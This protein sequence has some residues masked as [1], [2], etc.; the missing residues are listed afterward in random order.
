MNLKAQ[1]AALIKAAQETISAAKAED[2]DLTDA[3]IAD[4]ETKNA[5]IED[6]TAKLEK[7]E[8]S[9]ALVQSLTGAGAAYAEGQDGVTAGA[10]ADLSS[11]GSR[12]TGSKAYTG[13][14]AA[15]P[16]GVGQG[17][18]VDIGKVS[19]GSGDEWFKSR[20]L[21]K[22]GVIGSPAA[23]VEAARY[24]TVVLAERTE[25]TLLDLI[26]RGTANG[27][28]EYLQ[29][30]SVTR[31]GAVVP[32]ATNDT[33]TASLKPQSDFGTNLADAKP[34]TYAD[35]Y[36][37]TNQLLADAPALASYLNSEVSYT[38]DGVI[39]DKWLNGTGLNGEPRGLLNTTGV[40]SLE[41]TEAVGD[42][43]PLVKA[44]RRGITGI[45]KVPGASVTGI[46]ISPE[47]E[48]LIDLMQDAN[49]RFYGQGPFSAGPGTLWGRPRVVSDRIEQGQFVLGDFR[50]S[51]FLDVEGLSILAFNQH[52]DYAQR[53]LTYVRAELRGEQVFWKPAAFLHGGPTV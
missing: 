30:T 7:A 43:M 40:Q 28:F 52:K 18:N 25:L 10:T 44:A 1:R 11:F 20:A 53:N 8:K 46:V 12:F 16:T 2:R 47:D 9:A 5:E 33:E 32:E 14:K 26:G 38:L 6:L 23:H 15:N 4:L 37:V 39:E 48:E 22:A 34:Y 29:I 36:T 50:Q 24:P 27:A 51:Q 49:D 31:N 42:A 21:R 35:G 13:F 17:S 41:Y 19:V 3:E 45:R